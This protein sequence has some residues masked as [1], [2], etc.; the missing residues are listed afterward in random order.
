MVDV[1]WAQKSWGSQEQA[2]MSEGV[3]VQHL[4]INEGERLPLR[5][6]GDF[7]EHWIVVKGAGR[8]HLESKDFLVETG[9]TV[10]IPPRTRFAVANL[11]EGTLRLVAVHCGDE[12]NRKRDTMSDA[13]R[14]LRKLA[15]TPAE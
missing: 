15:V 12:R 3:S 6:N 7:P 1:D 5:M 4:R 13:L 9:S 11:G 8:V 14:A 10:F 2:D